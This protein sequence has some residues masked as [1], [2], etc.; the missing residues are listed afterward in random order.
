MTR[1]RAQLAHCASTLQT[2][3]LFA[4]R[5]RTYTA[6]PSDA[7]FWALSYAIWHV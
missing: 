6:R 1:G 2:R 7:Y 5:S 3:L 4:D